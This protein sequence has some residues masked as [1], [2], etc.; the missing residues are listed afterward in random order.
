[1]KVSITVS[2]FNSFATMDVT[3][4]YEDGDGGQNFVRNVGTIRQSAVTI[5]NVEA[6]TLELAILDAADAIR[7]EKLRE[8]AEGM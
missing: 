5:F 3:A 6:S 1:M 8:R 4:I 7:N 2:K